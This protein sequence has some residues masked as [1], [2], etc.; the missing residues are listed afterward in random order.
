MLHTATS[1]TPL[2]TLAH[3]IARASLNNNIFAL[4]QNKLR[5]IFAIA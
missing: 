2:R 3:L 5:G 1:L 4:A